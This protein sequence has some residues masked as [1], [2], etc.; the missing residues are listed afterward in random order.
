LPLRGALRVDGLR[1]LL[2]DELS[3]VIERTPGEDFADI[4]LLLGRDAL[5]LR[6]GVEDCEREFGWRATASARSGGLVRRPGRQ[7]HAG[8]GPVAVTRS[9]LAEKRAGRLLG[10]GA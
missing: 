8:D 2:G 7:E 9:E 3:T 10:V 4:V 1:D 5:T 6:P